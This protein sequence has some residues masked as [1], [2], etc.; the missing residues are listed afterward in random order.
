M[1]AKQ[2]AIS[3]S[4]R[5]PQLGI[6]K[7]TVKNISPAPPKPEYH[8]YVIEAIKL[9]YAKAP[10]ELSSDELEQFEEYYN[11]KKSKG[12]T[13]EEDFVYKPRST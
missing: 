10:D 8:P 5:S 6:S 3:V 7:T 1:L 9:M 4:P 13:I 12:E 2:S 11:W